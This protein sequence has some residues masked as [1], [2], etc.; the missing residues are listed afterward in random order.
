MPQDKRPS[1]ILKAASD[2]NLFEIKE[3]ENA[4]KEV[5][6]TSETL[7]QKKKQIAVAQKWA[8]PPRIKNLPSKKSKKH[9]SITD[10]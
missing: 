10:D 9:G 6:Q 7:T 2:R 8:P 4:S 5:E 3:V 1:K